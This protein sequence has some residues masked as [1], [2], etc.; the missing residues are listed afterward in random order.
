MSISFQLACSPL[1][2]AVDFLGAVIPQQPVALVASHFL[3][4]DR[5]AIH[6]LL[7]RLAF[8][9]GLFGHGVQFVPANR[10]GF[11]QQPLTKLLIF[12]ASPRQEGDKAAMLTRDVVHVLA[13][14]QLA[15]RHIQE[16]GAPH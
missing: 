6:C 1:G 11:L 4:T 7:E 14:R 3:R 10:I 2:V 13:G 8:D 12:F 15:I 16:I 9:D 5:Q